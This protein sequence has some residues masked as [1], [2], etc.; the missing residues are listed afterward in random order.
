MNP[1]RV[2]KRQGSEEQDILVA[3]LVRCCHRLIPQPERLRLPCRHILVLGARGFME[4]DRH[5]SRTRHGLPAYGARAVPDV[6]GPT[7]RS[8]AIRAA[9][10]LE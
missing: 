9:G 3:I 10:L 2:R 7:G 6:D 5:L 4:D 8:R 1:L